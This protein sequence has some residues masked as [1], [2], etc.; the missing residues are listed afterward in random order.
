MDTQTLAGRLPIAGPLADV[1]N[2]LENAQHL[3]AL[4]LQLAELVHRRS[5]REHALARQIECVT[6]MCRAAA[7]RS[8]RVAELWKQTEAQ[9]AGI[10]AAM[11]QARQSCEARRALESPCKNT[12]PG[13]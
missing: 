13:G 3:N 9:L 10:N 1:E 8:E 6:N 12:P 4:T 7:Q 11:A 2:F 5:R